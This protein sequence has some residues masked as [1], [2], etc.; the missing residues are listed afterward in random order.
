[1]M[2]MVNLVIVMVMVTTIRGGRWGS[3][4]DPP[5]LLFA[6]VCW[7][8]RIALQQISQ[9]VCPGEHILC[10]MFWS[11]FG[12]IFDPYPISWRHILRYLP[13]TDTPMCDPWA[14]VQFNKH[15]CKWEVR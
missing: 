10:K 5:E 13:N 3:Q 11:I 2:V 7:S 12:S 4:L 1:M 14:A 8:A 9:A 6:G 15:Q